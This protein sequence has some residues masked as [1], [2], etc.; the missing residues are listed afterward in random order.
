[1]EAAR[2]DQAGQKLEGRW[3]F[4]RTVR[5][6]GGLVVIKAAAAPKQSVEQLREEVRE[7]RAEVSRYRS[8][9]EEIA[10]LLDDVR[11]RV[12]DIESHS[13]LSA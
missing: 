12:R 11:A 9:R 6:E 10:T 4:Q 13:S 1:M 3:R 7:L 2:M 5:R 8:E